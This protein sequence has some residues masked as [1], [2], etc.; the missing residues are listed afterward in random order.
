L[1]ARATDF[2]HRVEGDA[3][4]LEFTLPSGSYAT[5]LLEQLYGPL[6]DGLPENLGPGPGER[7]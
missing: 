2:E 4:K 3:M 1:R 6:R 7:T 5:V